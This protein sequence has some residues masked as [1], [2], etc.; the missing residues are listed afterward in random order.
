MLAKAKGLKVISRWGVGVDAVDLDAAQEFGIKVA[1][2]SI[3]RKSLWDIL[4]IGAGLVQPIIYLGHR[5]SGHRP[6]FHHEFFHI[7]K[8]LPYFGFKKIEFKLK[9]FKSVL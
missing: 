3:A 9:S 5:L 1:R 4:S 6:T 2:I 8:R 7:D